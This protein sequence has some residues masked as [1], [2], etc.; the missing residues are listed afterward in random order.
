MG[1]NQ[2]VSE[3]VSQDACALSLQLCQTLCDPVDGSLPVS[4][5]YGI[6][7]S[8]IPE[9]VAMPSSSE[10]SR[11]RDQSCVSFISSVFF[12]LQGEK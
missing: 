11:P 5:V 8:R 9:Q 7:Q 10:S 6:L 2:E 3:G 12:I 1:L 4:S